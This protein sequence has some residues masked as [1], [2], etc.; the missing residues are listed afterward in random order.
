MSWIPSGKNSIEHH[1]NCVTLLKDLS[2]SELRRKYN[3]GQ[4]EYFHLVLW[5]WI[6]TDNAKGIVRFFKEGHDKETIKYCNYRLEKERYK[7]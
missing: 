6:G 4:L 7:G 2:E 3:N 1:L 5:G